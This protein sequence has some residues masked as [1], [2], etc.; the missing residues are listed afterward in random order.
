VE[1]VGGGAVI[2]GDDDDAGDDAAP[3]AR[4]PLR[5]VLAPEHD[6]VAFADL[7]GREPGGKRTGGACDLRVAVPANTVPVVVNQ[8][9]AAVGIE[10]AEEVNQGVASHVAAIDEL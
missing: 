4:D 2:D 9:I 7:R 10:I 6:L 5:P 1:E 8:E 3:V